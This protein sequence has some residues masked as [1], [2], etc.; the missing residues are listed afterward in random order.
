MMN[1]RYSSAI[2]ALLLGAVT[3]PAEETPPA[4]SE[5]VP[6]YQLKNRSA[7]AEVDENCRAPFWP[8]GWVKRKV[9]AAS[10][11]AP[12]VPTVLLDGKN[13]KV[14]SIL[15]GSGATPSL[16]VING[17]AYSEGEFLR[18]PRS[19]GTTPPRVRVQRINDGNVVLQN[20]E[21]LLVAALQRPELSARKSEELLLDPDR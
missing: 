1:S 9:G 16:A 3:L 19:A 8:I 14:T 5:S 11:A 12:T 10:V 13:Y 21:Q 17:R 6:P 20:A 7:F 4:K 18:T 15:L 2:V